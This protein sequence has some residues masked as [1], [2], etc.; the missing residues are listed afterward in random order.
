MHLN[1]ITNYKQTTNKAHIYVIRTLIEFSINQF[2]N[3][4]VI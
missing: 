3:I 4:E 1:Q 2:I